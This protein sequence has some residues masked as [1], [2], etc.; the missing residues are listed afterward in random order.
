MSVTT[1]L[2]TR[3][4]TRCGTE[5]A[6]GL[7]ACP[8][9]RQ[10]VHADELKRIAAEAERA[11][12]EGDRAT[13]ASR[14]Q[15]A[16]RLLPPDTAQARTIASRVEAL[17]GQMLTKSRAESEPAHSSSWLKGGGAL[18]AVALLLWKFKFLVVLLL[19][20]GKLLL[21]GLT[22]MSTLASMLLSFG[23]YW[24]VWGW[25]FAAGLIVSIYIHEMGHVAWL[26][27]YGI[28][29]S[30]PMFIPGIG[31]F[32]RMH[33][34]PA[35]PGIDA[36]VGLA[37][38]MWGF[39]AAVLAWLIFLATGA[40]IFGAIARV[41]AWI[42]LFNLL[43]FASLDGGRGFRALTKRERLIAAGVIGV[44]WYVTAEPLLILL[45]IAAAIQAFMTPAEKSDMTVL[46]SYSALVVFLAAL[47]KLPIDPGAAN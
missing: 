23:V 11:E 42:N 45:L 28:K 35:A 18:S 7:L 2:A 14:W 32:V 47:T 1:P 36:R 16:L 33:Q 20:K 39:G 8:R 21:L 6:P 13:A 29:A 15:D 17:G 22:K 34:Y 31:A 3:A 38:P 43:P 12:A 5:L 37:G 41:G 30:A 26:A 27:R 10:L 24:A 4:C 25:A 9:C 46:T 40:E 19:T 44:T